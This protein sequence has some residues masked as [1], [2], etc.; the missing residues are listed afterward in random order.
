MNPPH[1]NLFHIHSFLTPLNPA[2]M[3][4]RPFLTRLS[5]CSLRA[6]SGAGEVPA[7]Q[8]EPGRAEQMAR[9]G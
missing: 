3:P 8:R 6:A 9:E 4:P 2:C 7:G 1:P 5:N